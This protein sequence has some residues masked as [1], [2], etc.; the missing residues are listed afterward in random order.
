[1][2]CVICNSMQAFHAGGYATQLIW[3][4][5]N[6]I[7]LCLQICA[8]RMSASRN[9]FFIQ[10]IFLNLGWSHTLSQIYFKMFSFLLLVVRYLVAT[11]QPSGSGAKTEIVD[12][13]DPSKSCLLEDISYRRYSA[14]GLLGTTPV[15]CGGYNGYYFNECLLYGTSQVITM[16]SYR[17]LHSSVALN[18]S[19]LWML[20]GYTLSLIHI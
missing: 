14:G 13:S 7:Q 2:L 11:G 9:L 6:P 16:N 20:G 1:M 5:K 19:M 8:E 15:I 4:M 12:L 17:Y 10:C 18:E 3:L